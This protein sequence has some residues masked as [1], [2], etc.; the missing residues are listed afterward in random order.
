MSGWNAWFAMLAGVALKST[1][2]LGAAWLAAFLLRGWS[3]AARHLVW[4]A[5]AAAVLALPFL[6]IALP[7][8][9][10][11]VADALLSNANVVFETTATTRADAATTRTPQPG[12]AP[13]K[14][15]PAAWRP[16]WRLLAVLLW[17]AGSAAAF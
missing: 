17:A 3:A 8:W 6:S 15:L 12:S 4:T 14:S 16:D 10:I 13:G 5:A 7:P 9:R 2:V 11:S 1:A